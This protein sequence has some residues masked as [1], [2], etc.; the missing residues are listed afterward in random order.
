MSSPV[1]PISAIV[2]ALEKLVLRGGRWATIDIPIRYGFWQ[3]SGL[4]PMLIDT[5]Y[6]PRATEG[7]T[8]SFALKFYSALLRPRLAARNLP[9]TWLRARGIE[10]EKITQIIVTHFHADHVAALRDF[11]KARFLASGEAFD[12]LSRMSRR[13]QFDNAFFP[14]LLPPDF[15]DRLI[16]I[17]DRP[18]ITLP[19]DLGTG[20]DL[21][22]DGSCLAVPLPGHAL[23]H[24]GLLWPDLS[25]PLLYAVDTQWLLGAIVEGRSP[26]GPARLIY[27][28]RLAA[29]QS[30]EKVRRFAAAG[31][32]VMLCHEPADDGGEADA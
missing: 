9:R 20:F 23:G 25:P 7:S 13:K 28:D 15:G 1:F 17:E 4:G 21:F 5:G 16:R 8:R 14:E 26:K 18:E 12:R 19:F 27:S 2:R 11:P 10:P 32:R 6:T 31:G 22:G 24:F 30:T 29:E 3:H